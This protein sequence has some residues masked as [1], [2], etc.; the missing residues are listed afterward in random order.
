MDRDQCC[1]SQP[2][3]IRVCVDG[4]SAPARSNLPKTER[5]RRSI[6]LLHTQKSYAQPSSPSHRTPHQRT[7][8]PLSTTAGVLHYRF[9][10][11]THNPTDCR[12]RTEDTKSH[13]S[14]G[15]MPQ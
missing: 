11:T 3:P 5:S 13:Q 12:D 10:V 4:A 2:L 14:F 9:V 1:T 6:C 8:L 15:L 7:L